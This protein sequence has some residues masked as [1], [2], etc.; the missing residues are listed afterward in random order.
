MNDEKTTN[1]DDSY[2]N[3]SLI[4][5]YSYQINNDSI[6]TGSLRYSDSFLNYDEVTSGRTDANNSTDDDELSYNLSLTSKK[7]NLIIHFPTVIQE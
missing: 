5:N 7:I 1:D 4:A 3:E 2:K 6:L